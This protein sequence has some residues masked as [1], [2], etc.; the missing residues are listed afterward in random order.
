MLGDGYNEAESVSKSAL[1]VY[2]YL[3][4][5]IPYAQALTAAGV[6]PV[7]EEAWQGMRLGSRDGLLLTGGGDINPRLYGELPA[8]ETEPA[9]DD[10]DAAEAALIDDALA[11]G[12]ALLAICRGMQ[13]LNVRLG[14]T[15]TQHLR[16][17]ERHVRRTPDPGAPAHTVRI[18]PGTLLAAIAGRETWEVNS[19]HHQAVSRLGRGLRVGAVDPETETIEAIE[20]AG[21]RFVI[22]VQWH[23]ENQA[24]TDPEQHRL[25]QRFAQAVSAV[26]LPMRSPAD[27]I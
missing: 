23:P 1:V 14:G 12:V 8:P 13:M 22:G 6:E 15:L 24:P 16:D 5:A 4:E 9:D 10:R 7:L 3:P 26:T 21:A 25:F 11:C 19:R 20:V 17:T 27:P 2:R 18:E